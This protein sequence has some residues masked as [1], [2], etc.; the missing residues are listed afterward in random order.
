SSGAPSS[1]RVRLGASPEAAAGRVARLLLGRSV[2]LALGG[3][4]ARGFAHLGVIQE[5]VRAGAPIDF[6]A[7]TSMG[8]VMGAYFVANGLDSTVA[9]ALERNRPLDWLRLLDPMMF[10][11]GMV[12]GKK[13]ERFLERMLDRQAFEELDVP[14]A[15]IALDIDSGEEHVLTRGRL[16]DGLLATI[17]IPGVF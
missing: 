2:G 1:R 5:M 16:V 12:R 9:R 7:G 8:A 10:V 13:L 15:F 6:I 17:S 3:G 14:L 4:G 11:S